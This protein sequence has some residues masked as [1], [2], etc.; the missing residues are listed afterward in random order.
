MSV[1]G[2]SERH[3]TIPASAVETSPVQSTWLDCALPLL[4]Q[5]T[6][7]PA[8]ATGSLEFGAGTVLVENGRVCWAT[9][10]RMRRR[11]TDLLCHQK[12]PPLAR[13]AVEAV[14]RACRASGRPFGEALV[15]AG[16]ATAE[17]LRSALRQHV[18]ESVALIAGRES[19]LESAVWRP[20]TKQR[21]DARFTF[22]VAELLSTLGALEDVA[23]AATARRWL[24]YAIAGAGRGVA[25]AQLGQRRALPIGVVA[26]DDL[27]VSEVLE[28]SDWAS[29]T[30]QVSTCLCENPIVAST[31]NGG[32]QTILWQHRNVCLAML[33]ESPHD[34]ARTLGRLQRLLESA[35]GADAFEAALARVEASAISG[36]RA[37]SH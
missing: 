7:L 2:S 33:F 30:L 19:S 14:V 35:D 1:I 32:I 26:A 31:W 10:P 15:E 17:G 37:T 27:G 13:G 28:L 20:H 25:L 21:Y 3:S 9:S 29:S 22:S 34:W 5:L 24:K 23:L 4:E 16:L 8:D 18:A 12:S 11:L 6:T 36:V